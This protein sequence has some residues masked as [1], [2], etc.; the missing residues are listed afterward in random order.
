MKRFNENVKILGSPWMQV[1]PKPFL[2]NKS[3]VFLVQKFAYKILYG[4][5]G[6]VNV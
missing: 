1:W 2:P 3:K 6:E 5:S 4:L